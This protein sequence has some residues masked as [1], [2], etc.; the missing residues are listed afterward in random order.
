LVEQEATLRAQLAEQSSTLLEKHPRIKEL[1]AQIFD[2]DRRIRGEA[3]KVVRS[4]ENDARIAATRVETLNANLEQLKTQASS[5]N[6]QDVQLR[7]LERDAKAQRDLLESYLAK[8]REASARDSLSIVPSE[9]RIISRAAVSNTPYFPKK[10]PTVL[11][12]TL[13]MMALSIGFVVTGEVLFGNALRPVFVETSPVPAAPE[14]RVESTELK[15]ESTHFF[16]T[17]ENELSEQEAETLAAEVAASLA[18]AEPDAAKQLADGI[19]SVGGAAQCITVF[20]AERG[21]GATATAVALARALAEEGKVVLL[22]LALAVPAIADISRD[23]DSPGIAD[24]VRGTA[25][26]RHIITRDRYSRVHLIAAGQ[27]SSDAVNILSSDRLAIAVSALRRTYDHVVID[28]GHLT[29]LAIER[30]A[31][32]SQQAV[33]VAPEIPDHQVETARSRLAGAGF[34]NVVVFTDKV[35]RPDEIAHRSPAAA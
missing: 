16:Q 14:P 18:P 23:P 27:V 28:A 20:G 19:R 15:P 6:E 30:L 1:K 4:F 34:S 7:A 26:F 22:D 11:I 29:E 31:E 3:E 33:L 12:A 32:I 25:S 2:L 21:I 8:Y 13:A 17:V 5:S 9:A 10:L 35:P 24:L